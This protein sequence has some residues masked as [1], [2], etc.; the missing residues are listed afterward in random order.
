VVCGQRKRLLC[1]S[2]VPSAYVCRPTRLP[3]ER[4]AI[5][6]GPDA[7]LGGVR[8]SG[9]PRERR[10]P[11]T[12]D[13]RSSAEATWRLAA[14]GGDP[15]A[16]LSAGVRAAATQHIDDLPPGKVRLGRREAESNA[17]HPGCARRFRICNPMAC[18]VQRQRDHD[19]SQH[20][21]T[22]HRTPTQC[23]EAETM[24]GKSGINWAAGRPLKRERLPPTRVSHS[25]PRGQALAEAV[26]RP[27][28]ASR[29]RD[30]KSSPSRA[31]WP[32]PRRP[33]AQWHR[34]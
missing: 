8:R 7:A 1:R 21:S 28:Q 18:D 16:A 12:R 13:A 34:A 32:L 25:A 33:C 15:R 22:P 17:A 3:A 26:P 24:C 30:L 11:R 27:G 23:Q 6:L 31:A 9:S 20:G 19:G 14:A 10:E 5:G 29:C 4:A 2:A